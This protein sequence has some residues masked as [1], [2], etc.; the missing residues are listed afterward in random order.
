MNDTLL[1]AR[2]IRSLVLSR[3][4]PQ[5]SAKVDLEYLI[6]SRKSENVKYY[7]V[8]VFEFGAVLRNSKASP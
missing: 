4:L 5:T 8:Y 7:R 3:N 2:F 6:F 1:R